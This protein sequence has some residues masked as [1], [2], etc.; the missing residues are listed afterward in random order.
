M[1]SPIH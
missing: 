1:D